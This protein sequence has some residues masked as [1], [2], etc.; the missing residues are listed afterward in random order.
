MSD[1][2]TSA[3]ATELAL[4]R[5]ELKKKDVQFE[6][7]QVVLA[8]K[9]KDTEKLEAAVEHR[10]IVIAQL[11]SSR[12]LVF[13]ECHRAC[14][15]NQVELR[16][17]QDALHRVSRQLQRERR[18]HAV[19]V[20][21]LRGRNSSSSI[22]GMSKQRSPTMMTSFVLDDDD[23]AGEAAPWDDDL[24]TVLGAT[25]LCLDEIE[26]PLTPSHRLPVTATAADDSSCEEVD[27]L[28]W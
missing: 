1:S 8:A 16:Q 3:L 15:A 18:E 21:D 2:A 10:D 19:I 11:A 17:M 22:T 27:F 5:V 7:L 26:A 12:K 4:L 24:D 25:G 23:D 9:Q 20:K 13:E 6:E 14:N 28:T